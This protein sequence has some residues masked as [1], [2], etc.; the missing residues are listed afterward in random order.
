MFP[1]RVRHTRFEA[2]PRSDIRK[3]SSY[4]HDNSD[5]LANKDHGLEFS[6]EKLL[7]VSLFQKKIRARVRSYR[8]DPHCCLLTLIIF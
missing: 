6:F 2:T 1:G 5:L 4:D 3:S 7:L 8:K